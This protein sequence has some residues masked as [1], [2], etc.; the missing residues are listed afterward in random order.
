M[1]LLDN[2]SSYLQLPPT[3]YKITLYTP[4][5]LEISWEVF[6]KKSADILSCR[7][8][9]ITISSLLIVWVKV[10]KIQSVFSLENNSG[11]KFHMQYLVDYD[12]KI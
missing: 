1:A 5:H 10:T 9:F 11:I 4:G 8:S 7:N 2:F 12:M 3:I 6:A